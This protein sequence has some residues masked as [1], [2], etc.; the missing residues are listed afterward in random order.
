MVWWTTRWG[1][2]V[3]VNEAK[4][5]IAI[6]AI[7]TQRM[8]SA[9]G[10]ISLRTPMAVSFPSSSPLRMGSDGIS[11]PVSGVVATPTRLPGGPGVLNW[12]DHDDLRQGPPP[13][14]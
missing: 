13:A 9:I 1:C 8:A 14:V 2:V 6:A 7:N 10:N 11:A 3:A 4:S 12:P 5:T